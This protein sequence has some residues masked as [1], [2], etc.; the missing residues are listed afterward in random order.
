MRDDPGPQA[1]RYQEQ[2]CMNSEVLLG[3]STRDVTY[4]SDTLLAK[5]SHLRGHLIVVPF[6]ISVE[7][8]SR[9]HPAKHTRAVTFKQHG[10]LWRH[11]G[12]H[13]GLS[14]RLISVYT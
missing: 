14:S 8:E 1:L 10:G 7:A 9:R 4:T 13:P 6:Q 12:A 2:V 5:L 3:L 11:Y